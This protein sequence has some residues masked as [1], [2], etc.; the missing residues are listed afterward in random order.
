[1]KK[2]VLLS[3]STAFGEAE[4]LGLMSACAILLIVAIHHFL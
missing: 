3:G 2:A 1:M 4:K